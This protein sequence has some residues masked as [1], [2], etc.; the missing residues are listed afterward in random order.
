MTR[1]RTLVH[2]VSAN[3]WGGAQQYALDICRHYRQRGWDVT[4]VTRDA[5]A[6]DSHFSKAEIP[7]IHAPLRGFIDPASAVRLA[8]FFRTLPKDTSYCHVHRYRDA[9]TALLA[10]KIAHRPDI[11]VISTRHKVSP[12]R[13][14]LLFRRIYRKIQAHIFVSETA[15]RRFSSTWDTLPF[16][17]GR[18]HILHNSTF[19]PPGLP[20]FEPDR[21]PVFALYAG[22]V[23]P[24]KGLETIIDALPSLRDLKFRLRIAGPG[25]PDY[26]DSIRSRAQARGVMEMIDWKITS[27]IPP[28]IYAQSHFAVLP[29]VERE[30]FG[31]PN[32]LAMAAGRPQV[33]SPNGAQ[34]EYLV[35]GHSALF[36]PPSNPPKLAEAMRALAT[37]PNRRRQMGNAAY[38]AYAKS[39]SWQSFIP[40]LDNIYLNS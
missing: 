2:I 37:D 36:V 21:G 27:D 11:R 23:A 35:D 10:K 28:G 29:S 33:C 8:S 22:T 1:Q 4:A 40:K 25:S 19:L 34:A 17:A 30:A 38:E 31:M 9:F 3:S 6:V 12:G 26:L 5:R 24:R 16:D 32:L 18:V 14:S 7:L 20:E 13:N 39:L 15:F